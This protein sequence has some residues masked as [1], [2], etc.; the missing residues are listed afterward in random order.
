[1]SIDWLLDLQKSLEFGKE[2]FAVQGVGKGVW[3][4]SRDKEALVSQAKSLADAKGFPITVYKL[5]PLSESVTGCVYLVPTKVE[6]SVHRGE[7]NIQWSLVETKDAAE[8]I[9]DLSQGPSPYFG[10]LEV[11]TVNPSN[12][13]S[14]Q[15]P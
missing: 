12:N 5:I 9:R 2:F 3:I 15:K 11:I 13:P 8:L 14:S 4:I 7:P 1:M 6:E 10:A